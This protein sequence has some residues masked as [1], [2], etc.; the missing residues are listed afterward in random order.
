MYGDASFAGL[1]TLQILNLYFNKLTKI[2]LM[3]CTQLQT[4]RCDYNHI[5]EIDLTTCK[6]LKVLYCGYIPLG[7]LNV[8]N[9]TQ[10]QELYSAQNRF[11][12]LDVTNNTQLQK[13]YC[14]SNEL[15]ELDLTGLD[16]LTEFIGVQQSPP[17]LTL[18]EN[19]VDEYTLAISLNNPTFANSAISY[20]DGILKSTDKNVIFTGFTVQTGKA[21]FVLSG[22]MGFEYFDVG[23]NPVETPQL[24]VRLNPVNNILLIECENY[25]TLKLYDMLGKEVLSENGRDTTEININYLPKGVYIVSVFSEDKV[26]GTTKIMKQQ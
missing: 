11:T 14:G 8:T 1:T 20:A 22:T 26:I 17:P 24:N 2:D 12:Y 10:L 16:K 3:N 9:L 4:F 18:Y 13:L 23:I 21:G 6:Q 7:K 25:Y 5:T 15:T 19:E